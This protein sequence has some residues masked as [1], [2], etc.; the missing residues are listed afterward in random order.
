MKLLITSIILNLSIISGCTKKPKSLSGSGNG[1]GENTPVFGL[2]GSASTTKYIGFGNREL[3]NERT[4]PEDIPE[5]GDRARVKP[6]STFSKEY[7]RV[8]GIDPD[9]IANSAATFASA[10]E[11]WYIEPQATATTIFVSYKIGYESCL[12]MLEADPASDQVPTTESAT[13]DCTEIAQKAWQRDPS[14]EEVAACVK[15]AVEDTASESD[16]RVRKAHACASVMTAA[17]FLSY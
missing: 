6:Y 17:G 15:V 8:T 2:C 9:A 13:K 14:S 16:N 10:P 12:K 11:R 5:D 4:K 7:V 1:T 3:G